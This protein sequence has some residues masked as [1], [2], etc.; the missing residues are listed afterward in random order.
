MT[1]S[2]VTIMVAFTT[3]DTAPHDANC[4]SV[5]RSDVTRATS[6]PRRDS[7]WWRMLSS[8]TWANVRTRSE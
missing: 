2:A 3:H 7:P 5:S 6:T 8:C 4:A 1:L